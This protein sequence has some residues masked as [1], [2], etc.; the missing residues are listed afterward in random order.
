MSKLIVKKANTNPRSKKKGV[1][2]KPRGTMPVTAPNPFAAGIDIGSSE[3]FVCIII[4]GKQVVKSFGVMTRDLKQMVSWLKE[5]KVETVVMESTGYWWEA[6][7][8][9]IEEAKIEALLV[10]S[11]A[12]HSTLSRKTDVLDAARLQHLHAIGELRGCFRPPE[13]LVGIRSM[14][15]S[16]AKLTQESTRHLQR[17]GKLF[18]QMNLR[19]P[20]VLSDLG[21]DTAQ[22]I[23]KDILAGERDGMKLARHR[24]PTCKASKE[25]IAAALEGKWN[26]DLLHLIAIEQRLW[27]TMRTE[28]AQLRLKISERLQEWQPEVKKG[29]AAKPAADAQAKT[30]TTPPPVSEEPVAS[31]EST[32]KPRRA[33]RPKSPELLARESFE[34]LI[35][36]EIERLLGVDLTSAPAIGIDRA[37]TLLLELGD[38]DHFLRRFP[39]MRCFC[40]WTGL[41]PNPRVSGGKTLGQG[42]RRCNHVAQELRNA[43]MAMTRSSCAFG[44]YLRHLM[45]RM[46]SGKKAI[47]AAANKLARILY[48]MIR[49]GQPYDED[50][51]FPVTEARRQ[52]EIA[53][54]QR[55]AAK[56]G[57]KVEPIAAPALPEPV[58][59]A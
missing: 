21:G 19:L 26:D 15:R 36:D 55:K 14:M 4:N 49:D 30:T 52:R 8:Q 11:K 23:I 34:S 16:V 37:Q 39:S 44:I 13:S 18:I 40:A 38:R 54:I 9:I 58:K 25:E 32:A 59:E 45:S 41:V 50:R 12:L 1:K 27:S 43:V 24:Y 5:H 35:R 6:V 20:Q 42:N 7:M 29:A 46:P 57:L 22:A 53:F 28:I 48:A 33:G 31:P 17:T 51:A 2:K 10:D 3:I 56:H 47:K